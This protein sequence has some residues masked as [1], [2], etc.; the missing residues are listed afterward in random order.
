MG[1]RRGHV[2]QLPPASTRPASMGPMRMPD[3]FA[4][5]SPDETPKKGWKR[6]S[7]LGRYLEATLDALHLL[8][9]TNRAGY[10]V[11]QHPPPRWA[12]GKVVGIKGKGA[13]DYVG[14][15]VVAGQP[16]PVSIALEA[17]STRSGRIDIGN[18]EIVEPHQLDFFRRWCGIGLFVFAL[19]ERPGVNVWIVPAREVCNAVAGAM[20]HSL[21]VDAA[22]MAAHGG[23]ECKGADWLSSLP[24]V[25]PL[26]LVMR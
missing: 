23:V 26:A 5:A 8:Y 2:T 14:G 7:R 20:G 25:L 16:L 4:P 1:K 6:H 9:A 10:I 15:V 12:A 19:E 11:R 3:G 24:L 13:V 18:P 22:W 21:E 17:K